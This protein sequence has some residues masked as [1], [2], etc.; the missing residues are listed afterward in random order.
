[1]GGFIN[2]NTSWRWTFYILLIWSGIAYIAVVL[3]VP[4]TYAP[5][6]LEKKAARLRKETKDER[7]CASC[8]KPQ[9]SIIRTIAHSCLAPI[10]LLTLEPMCIVLCT[11]SAVLLGIL[12]L[13][14]EAFPLVFRVNHGFSL[15]DI[16]MTFLGLFVGTLVAISTDPLWHRLYS[17]LAAKSATTPPPPELRLLPAMAGGILVPVGIFWFAW[18]T[19]PSV[20]WIVPIIGSGVF[21]AGMLLSFSGV[22]TFLVDTYPHY[23]ASALAANSFMR[24]S[25]AAGFPLF[26]TQ[27]KCANRR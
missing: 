27:S 3:F 1:V 9:M 18:T 4:E 13:F 5:A 14:F 6:L 10:Q 17:R 11:F 12:Y 20:H 26:A 8:E 2:Q 16:G 19:Y 7:Y 25:F 23:A 22:W 21:G 24:S 15:Q